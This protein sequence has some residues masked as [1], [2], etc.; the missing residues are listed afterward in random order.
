M[1]PR[2]WSPGGYARRSTP[3]LSVRQRSPFRKSFMPSRR[4][5]LHWEPV[6][7]AMLDAPPLAGPAAVVSLRRHVPDPG[8]LEPGGLERADR[9]LAPGARALHEDLDLLEAVLHALARR[10]IRRDLRGE[11][12]GLARALE[13]GAA[14]GLPR[15]HVAV[16]V[17]QRHDRVVEAR[18]DRRLPEGHVLPGALA[19]A[20]PAWLRHLV[21]PH[22][23]LAAAGLG[24]ALRALPGPCIGLRP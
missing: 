10:G 4:H 13:A 1:R 22:L 6:S 9:R 14:G 11:G 18:L 19:P 12:R 23:L 2:P 8:D 20:G 16:P 7:R 21:L 17:G 15:D 5:C 24:A 3:H